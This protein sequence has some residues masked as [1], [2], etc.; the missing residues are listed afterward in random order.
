MPETGT[1]F[2]TITPPEESAG[3][4]IEDAEFQNIKK[5]AASISTAPHGIPTPLLELDA[6]Q[7]TIARTPNPRPVPAPDSPEVASCS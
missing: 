2:G 6:S 4:L 3:S 5:T 7:L 1:L